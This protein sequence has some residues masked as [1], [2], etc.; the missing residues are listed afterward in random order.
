LL[1]DQHRV[2]GERQLL[3]PVAGLPQGLYLL[4]LRTENGVQV[5]KFVK[6]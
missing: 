1:Q 2:H 6:Q 4:R 3:I 5:V